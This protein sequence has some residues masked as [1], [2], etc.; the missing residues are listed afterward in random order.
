[1]ELYFIRHGQSVSNANWHRSDFIPPPDPELTEAGHTQAA[2]LAEF[3]RERQPLRDDGFWNVQNHSGFGLTHLYTS[4]MQRAVDT[5][6]PVAKALDLPLVLWPE[7]HEEGGAFIRYPDGKE[8]CLPGTPRS[9]YEKHYPNLQLPDQLDEQGWWKS[10]PV[11][12][13]EERQVRAAQILNE[14]IARHGDQEGRPEQRV[15]IF[16]HGGFFVHFMSIVFQINYR[17]GAN[18][19][20]TWFFM[21]NTAITR[22]DIRKDEFLLCYVNRTEHLSAELIT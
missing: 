8:V 14:L 13:V 19:A 12:T 21:N 2:R 3:L 4:P 6:C 7:I 17:Q 5:A 20:K 22:I 16:S 11:E 1:M 18:G 10:R 9:Y 15:A